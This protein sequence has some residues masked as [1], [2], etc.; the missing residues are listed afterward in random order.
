M[1]YRL[2]RR[3]A[4]VAAVGIALVAAGCGAGSK[5]SASTTGSGSL[6][7]AWHQVVVCARAHGMPDMPE[8]TIDAN[9]NATFPGVAKQQIPQQTRAAC[10]AVVNRLIPSG[11]NHAYSQAQLNQLLQFARCMRSHGIHDWPDPNAN[12]EF[13][14]P[15][16]LTHLLK[17]AIRTPMIACDRYNPDPSGRIYGARP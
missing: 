11:S 6:R 14:L 5:P 4:L 9:G 1:S 8:P 17:S 10:Q 3:A 13:P 2:G 7:A 12:G 15:P 16:R